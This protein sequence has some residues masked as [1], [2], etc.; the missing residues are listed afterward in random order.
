MYPFNVKGQNSSTMPNVSSGGNLG[1]RCESILGIQESHSSSTKRFEPGRHRS[2]DLALPIESKVVAL[3][4]TP[5]ALEDV[6]RGLAQPCESVLGTLVNE[7]KIDCVAKVMHLS[8]DCPQHS[9]KGDRHFEQFISNLLKYGVLLASAI[10]LVG[11]I[12]YLIHHGTEL[13]DYRFFQG[14]PSEFCS[15]VGVLTAVLSGSPR[16]LIQLGLLI[17]I[18]TPIARVVFSFVA[19]LRQ[20]DFAYIIVTLCVLVALIYSMIG[21]YM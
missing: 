12:L 16:G 19:F 20:R 15:P 17:L 9:T 8:C 6:N 2:F 7:G 10:V 11:G 5:D 1:D 4:L 18:A 14:T 21:A 13:A 3:P